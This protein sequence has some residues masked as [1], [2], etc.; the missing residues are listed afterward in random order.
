VM[1][2]VLEIRALAAREIDAAL[3]ALYESEADAG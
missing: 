3:H 1:N 2:D